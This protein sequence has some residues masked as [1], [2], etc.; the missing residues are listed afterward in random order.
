M[1][2][3]VQPEVRLGRNFVREGDPLDVKMPGKPTFRKGFFF[4]GFDPK[5]GYALVKE[6]TKG[7]IRYVPLDAIRRRAV[8][9]NGERK[10]EKR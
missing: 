7:H 4:R 3:E 2:Q 8:T 1:S 9:K 10:I 5:S 6:P